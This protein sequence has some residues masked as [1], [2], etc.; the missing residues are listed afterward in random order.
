MSPQQSEVKKTEKFGKYFQRLAIITAAE[1]IN[2]TTIIK[3][4][5]ST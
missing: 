4:S 1:Q 5:I 3:Y 2:Y